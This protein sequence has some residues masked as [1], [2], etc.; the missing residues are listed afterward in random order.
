MK[1]LLFVLAL[2]FPLAAAA[3]WPDKPVR[4]VVPYVAG[5]MGDV[6]SRLLAEELRPKLA[7]PVIVDNRPGAGGNI[8]T[9][10]VA[11][12][13][14][15]G[16]TVVVG[17]TNNFVINQFLYR[18][19][20]FDPLQALA[21]VTILV[22][23]PSVIFVNA[24]VPGKTFAEFAQYAKSNKGKVNYGSPGA[25]TT[26]HLSAA[27][28]NQTRGLGM[29]H[30]PYKGAAQVVAALLANEVQFYM[31]GAG[32]GAQHV[33]AGKLHA[34]AVSNDKRVAALPDTPTFKE[35]GLGDINASNYW[36]VAVPKATP[37]EI[38]EKLYQAFRASLSTP[39]AKE[40][41]AKLG[42]VAVGTTPAETAKRW[43]EEAAF[44][45][46]AVKDMAVRI[47]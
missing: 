41:F 29:T 26:P 24:Q 2:V 8:G 36:A 13:E 32:L 37:P 9:G 34:V 27:L 16:Y 23:V 19:M 18:G 45:A 39:A 47:D 43:R 33:K 14:P 35:V 17:A 12:A 44:W 5:A 40:R 28:I 42:V 4:I 6:V 22:D 15:D 11:Q 38:V 46:K 20:G 1:K 21:P 31:G 30:I 25:G 3:E 7:Q 10:A